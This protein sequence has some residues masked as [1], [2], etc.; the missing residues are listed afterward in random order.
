MPTGKGWVCKIGQG[1]VA[2]GN[3]TATATFSAVTWGGPVTPPAVPT[4]DVT[5]R[6]FKYSSPGG[7]Y[8]LIGTAN[9]GITG[10]SKTTYTFPAF[11]APAMLFGSGDYVYVDLWWHDNNASV[12]GDNPSVYVSSSSTQGVANDM[13][14]VL[15]TFT[16]AKES[17]SLYVKKSAV[18]DTALTLG[19]TTSAN[20][21][22]VVVA[23]D[24]GAVAIGVVSGTALTA[25]QSNTILKS[26]LYVKKA[27]AGDTA[28]AL[29]ST[30]SANSL[31]VVIASDQSP[32]QVQ[33]VTGT[34]GGSTSYHTVVS[35]GTN[36]T[37]VKSSAGQVYDGALSNTSG[38]PIYFRFY[39]TSGTPTV[40]TTTIKR[41][42]QVPG[43]G[44]V[45]LSWP[46]GLKFTSGIAWGISTN[47]GDSDTTAISS[48]VSI[49]L[50]YN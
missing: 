21:V 27:T 45:I 13:Q 10:I 7:V 8:T 33:A 15:P 1:T 35:S 24:Q 3:W 17:V 48:S 28:L 26:S 41:T 9:V 44:T 47:I 2:A 6:F 30:T 46:N 37:N 38:S 40:G 31:P 25:D 29:G 50:G 34:T 49:D 20:S 22:P 14:I 4:T 12:N 5:I 11:S 42:I 18:G 32:V 23:S 16:V 36:G 19:S 39:D 43:N